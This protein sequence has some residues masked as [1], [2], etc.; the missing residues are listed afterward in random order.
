MQAPDGLKK[1]KA[2][3]NVTSWGVIP[4]DAPGKSTVEPE[5]CPGSE[6]AERA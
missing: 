2:H 1:R 4:F 5:K 6:M 3:C